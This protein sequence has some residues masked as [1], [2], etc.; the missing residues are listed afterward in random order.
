MMSCYS[1]RLAVFFSAAVLGASASSALAL[2]VGLGVKEVHPRLSYE[3][4]GADNVVKAKGYEYGLGLTAPLAETLDVTTLMSYGEGRGR[5]EFSRSSI[6]SLFEKTIHDRT[7]E[8]VYLGV[9]PKIEQFRSAML[10]ANVYAALV[11]LGV[12]SANTGPY[13]VIV[14][15]T[16]EHALGFSHVASRVPGQAV[17]DLAMNGFAGGIAVSYDLDR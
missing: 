17:K 3:L 14:D 13:H 1:K 15:I 8:F 10:E 6:A 9:G 11:S 2:E 5:R 16:Y 7:S 12:K 4:G